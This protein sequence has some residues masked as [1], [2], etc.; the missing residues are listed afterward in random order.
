MFSANLVLD[1]FLKKIFYFFFNFLQVVLKFRLGGV[2][3]KS[4]MG[5]PTSSHFVDGVKT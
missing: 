5:H 4:L 2:V 1:F 3:E